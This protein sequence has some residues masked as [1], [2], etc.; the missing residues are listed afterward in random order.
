MLYIKT[1]IFVS[2]KTMLISIM[3]TENKTLFKHAAILGLLISCGFIASAL[4]F[5]YKDIPIINNP[6]LIQMNVFLSITGI[7]LG[8]QKYRDDNLKGIISYAK[9]VKV[10]TLILF[11]AS[12]NYAVF[13]YVLV[14]FF[15]PEIKIQF[16]DSLEEGLKNAEYPDDL[17]DTIVSLYKQ[18]VSAGLISFFELVRKSFMGLAFS[19]VLAGF[20]KKKSAKK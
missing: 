13:S 9:A 8:I 5:I 11:L 2:I 14:S 16:V 20:L 6:K 18:T 15:N 19:L 3:P 12:I 10:G 1:D 17:V 4:F 7:F